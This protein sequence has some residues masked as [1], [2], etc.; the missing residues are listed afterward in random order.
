MRVVLISI[1]AMGSLI[2]YSTPVQAQG[3][4]LTGEMAS[5][6]DLL[7]GPWS[8]TTAVPAM[9]G[10]PA[11][12]DQVTVTFDVVPGN[13]IHDHVAGTTYTGDDYF[14]Y[15]PRMK[16][17]W[18]VSADNQGSHGSATSTD[19]KTYTGTS[20]MGS[21]AMNVTSTYSRVSA[22]NIT[23]HEVVSGNGEQEVFDSNC[24]R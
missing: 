14:G 7:G 12:T 9:M 23:L 6:N 18:S 5:S 2:G 11:H 21:M 17:Y 3:T 10:Q 20:S 13:V 19:A 16:M 1:L 8:C 24:K 15:S 4:L 22:G